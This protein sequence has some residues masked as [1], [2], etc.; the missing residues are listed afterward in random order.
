MEMDFIL[1][2]AAIGLI[3]GV[4]HQI[5]SKNG[6]EE[7]AQLTALAGL[8]VVVLLLLPQLLSLLDQVRSAF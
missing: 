3:V 2:I 5:L 4:L 1:K 7:Y 6:R 8:I